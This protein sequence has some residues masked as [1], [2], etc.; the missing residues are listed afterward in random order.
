MTPEEMQMLM[1]MMGNDGTGALQQELGAYDA[2]GPAGF[3]QH[4]GMGTLD[5]RGDLARQNTQDQSALMQQQMAMAEALRKPRD[6]GPRTNVTSAILG[7][8]GDI[9]RDLGGAYMQHKI[10]QKNEAAV[11]QG[12]AQQ[13]G[14]LD[15]M[16]AGRQSYGDARYDIGMPGLT[17]DPSLF[18]G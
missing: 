5:Q 13:Q 10:G 9:A 14:L 1:A 7:G 15:K 17:L 8:V 18:G 11:A 4:V 16:D 6:T 3:K 12:L 2:M